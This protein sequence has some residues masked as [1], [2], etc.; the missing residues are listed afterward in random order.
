MRAK[1][2]VFGTHLKGKTPANAIVLG[3]SHSQRSEE[4]PK[5]PPSDGSCLGTV[6]G[7]SGHLGVIFCRILGIPSD[8][9]G[10]VDVLGSPRTLLDG[11]PWSIWIDPP[12]FVRI[13]LK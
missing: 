7:A 2:P 8:F 12:V 5:R 11:G 1:L 10:A 13:K 3:A 6:L 4:P 9:A